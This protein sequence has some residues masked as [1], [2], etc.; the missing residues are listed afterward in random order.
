MGSDKSLVGTDKSSIYQWAW[1]DV[2]QPELEL[3]KDL[4]EFIR[5]VGEDYAYTV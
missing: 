4:R 2:I 1:E 5:R 3:W